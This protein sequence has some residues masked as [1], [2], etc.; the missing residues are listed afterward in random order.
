MKKV[1]HVLFFVT[2]LNQQYW[3]LNLKAGKQQTNI[4]QL[5]PYITILTFENLQEVGGEITRNKC[6]YYRFQIISRWNHQP[7]LNT[8]KQTHSLLTAGKKYN[9]KTLRDSG[10]KLWLFW[11]LPYLV[12]NPRPWSTRRPQMIFAWLVFLSQGKWANTCTCFWAWWALN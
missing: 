4:S 1:I 7:L 8:S 9:K 3:H 2:Q 11:I 5:I 12:Q 10:L 6:V